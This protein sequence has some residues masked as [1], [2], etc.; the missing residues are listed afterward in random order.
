MKVI[1]TSKDNRE[2]PININGNKTVTVA[3]DSKE[4]IAA[5]VGNLLSH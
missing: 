4:L 3:F 5:W 2:R 1:K